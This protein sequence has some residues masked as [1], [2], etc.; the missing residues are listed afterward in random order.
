MK[1]L[2]VVLVCLAMLVQPVSAARGGI[3]WARPV[4]RVWLPGGWTQVVDGLEGEIVLY[5]AR[6]GR[7]MLEVWQES[8]VP[9]GGFLVPPLR[10]YCDS[11]GNC[12]TTG[13][14]Y[15]HDAWLSLGAGVTHGERTSFKFEGNVPSGLF[16]VR[17]VVDKWHMQQRV[18][19]R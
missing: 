14:M 16:Q 2:L 8:Y 15:H 11:D 10:L 5:G 18:A 7:V 6:P 4:E 9:G 13:P 12:G 19:V 3:H 17:V 1:R